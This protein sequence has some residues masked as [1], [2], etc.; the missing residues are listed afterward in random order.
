MSK[1]I[2]CIPNFSEGR[3]PAVIDALVRTASNIPG[4]MLADHS[5]DENHNR[6]VL[7]LFGSP[8][9]IAAAAF[10]LAQR[11]AELIDLTKHTGE[12]PRMGAVDVI[13]FVPIRDTT[14]AECA[15]LAAGVAARI[16]AELN[17]P[18]IL[19]EE[20]ATA[21]HRRNLADIRKGGFEGMAKKL[22]KPEWTP[23]YGPSVPHPTAGAVAVGARHPLIAFNVNLSTSDVNIAKKIAKAV[24]GSSGGLKYCKALGIMLESR[25]IAQVS[26]NMVNYNE[27]PLYRAFELVKTEAA[28]YGV[29][30]TGSELIGLAPAKALIDCSEY[31]L[32]LEDFDYTRQVLEN[33]IV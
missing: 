19:Y 11:A 18:V 16:G 23:D 30:V 32:R 14:I 5:S 15:E 13:P 4:A 9:G 6:S 33:H 10:A 8:E 12:H 27:T 26:M 17:I 20:A 29:S 28:R 21:P 22:Q 2:E 31:Y 7:T 25:N 1:L 3:D 24:R